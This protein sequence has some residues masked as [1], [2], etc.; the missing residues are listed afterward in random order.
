MVCRR[1]RGTLGKGAVFCHGRHLAQGP[2]A[3]VRGVLESVL[4]RQGGIV[5]DYAG[6]PLE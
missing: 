4:F 1:L 5:C 6:G 2:A 3:F